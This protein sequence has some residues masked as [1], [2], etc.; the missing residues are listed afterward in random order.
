MKIRLYL[1]VFAFFWALFALTNNG[2][3]LSEGN[4][5]YMVA[6]QIVRNGRLS[7]DSVPPSSVFTLAPDGKFYGSHEIGNALFLLPTAFFNDLIVKLGSLVGK[8]IPVYQAYTISNPQAFILSFQAGVYSAIT[9]TTFF[10]ILRTRFFLTIRSSFLATFCLATTTFF[11]TYSR[12]LF[13]GVLSCTLLTL[14]FF[15]LS[16]YR[17]ER[18]ASYLL[19]AFV[20]L[21][22]AL[23]TRISCVFAI[24]SS[25]IYLCGIQESRQQKA[26]RIAIALLTL[27]PFIVWQCWYNHVRT[28]SYFTS[29]VQSAKYAT[30]NALDGNLLIGIL[31]YLI[32][33]GKSLFVFAPLLA[34][35]VL[36]FRKFYQEYKHEAIYVGVLSILWLLLHSRMRSWYGAWGWGP[37][38]FVSI[39]PLM[40]LPFAVNIE[41]IYQKVSLRLIALC[42]GLFGFLLAFS[43]M[44]SSFLIRIDYAIQNHRFDDRQFVWGI[45]HS[46]SIDMLIA[47]W[48]NVHR[49]IFRSAQPLKAKL[50]NQ[51]LDY[52]ANTVNTWILHATKIPTSVRFAAAAFLILL[53]VFSLKY[54]LSKAESKRSF[55]I[56]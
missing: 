31:G 5:H 13:D 11:W 10:A 24:I 20:C 52:A 56:S 23:I 15:F 35:S 38:L 9:A 53:M 33:P 28:G 47:G 34:L 46:Q 29:A 22:F 43:S 48:S 12:N 44:I 27:V 39:L 50:F 17:V 6:E 42:L 40:F 19:S 1:S 21:G 30:N 37:R 2:A 41:A 18:K 49:F 36:F 7:L 16:N 51:Q 26:R 14:S 55:S 8:K 32:S 54:V 3:D 4:Y 45:W 25:V